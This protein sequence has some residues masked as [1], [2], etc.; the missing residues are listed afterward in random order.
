MI[1]IIFIARNYGNCVIEKTDF[2]GTPTFSLIENNVEL[3]GLILIKAENESGNQ[4]K[5]F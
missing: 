3:E 2:R 4:I 5:Y 1:C